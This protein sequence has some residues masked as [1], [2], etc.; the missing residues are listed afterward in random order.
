MELSFDPRKNIGV[1]EYFF[2]YAQN[3][4]YLL[5]SFNRYRKTFKN[6]IEVIRKFRANESEI[7]CVLKNGDTKTLSRFEIIMHTRNTEK[8]CKIT[9]DILSIK[10]RDLE[11]ILMTDWQENGDFFS[12]VLYD[13]EYELIDIAEKDV[14]DVGANNGDTSIYFARRGAKNVIALEP[15]P[16]NFESVKKNIELNNLTTIINPIMAGL[17]GEH[18]QFNISENLKGAS[19]SADD[20]GVGIN[21]PIITLDEILELSKNDQRVLKLDC[22]GCEYETFLHA[23][24]DTLQNFNQILIA[25]HFG[26]KNL[27]KKLGESGFTVTYS[28]PRYYYRNQQSPSN[29]FLGHIF[30]CRT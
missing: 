13:D 14:I 11:E 17:G 30:A 8:F 16:S 1:G 19:Y 28:K 4:N 20:S 2:S 24:K 23:S 7:N 5:E 12:T 15:L 10:I 27:V 3:Y 25:Y 22:E 21:V 26:Y 9:D 29:M 6:Y 18:D